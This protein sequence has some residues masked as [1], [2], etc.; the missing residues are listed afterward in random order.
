MAED[1][2]KNS[3]TAEQQKILDSKAKNLVISAS[4]GSGK[5]FILIEKIK[6][7]ICENKVKVEKL[8]VLTF[9]KV[10][11][12]EIKSR[13]TNAILSQKPTKELIESLD[14]LPLSDISTIDSFCEKIIKRNINKLNISENFTILDEKTALKLKKIA[15]LNTYQ[16]F[17]QNEKEKFDEIYFAF[18]KNKDAVEDCVMAL[19]DKFSSL[20]EG[21]ELLQTFEKDAGKLNDLAQESLISYFKQCFDISKTILESVDDG[22]LTQSEKD[23]FALLNEIVKL[24][25][26][27]NIFLVCQNI[28]NIALPSL[29]GR[30]KEE[31][32]YSFSNAKYYIKKAFDI[33]AKYRYIP[34][35]AKDKADSGMLVK[36][37]IAFYRHFIN[38]YNDLKLK[39]SALDFA[40]IE[41]YAKKLLQDDE[42]KKA[43]QERYDYIFI[44][45]YQD[46][47]RLQES[48]LKPISEG[49][50]FTA[51]GDIKQ[52]IYGFRNA[53]ME[54]MLSDI[55]NFSKNLDG[56]AL[57]LNGNFRTEKGILSFV[58]IIFEK[59]MT[60][61]SV[62]I[63]Y[64]DNSM[65]LGLQEFIRD[66]LPPVTVD[67]IVQE[68]KKALDNEE[69]ECEQEPREV[70]DITK[71]KLLG[72]DSQEAE[73]CTIIERIEEVLD[74]EIYDAK[75]KK[76]RRVQQNDIALLFRGRS[77]LM[78]EVVRR[79]RNLG[80]SVEADLKQSL[81][82]D[83][84]IAVICALLKLT[85]N[86]KDDISL[87][88]VMASIFGGFSIDE[89]AELRFNNRES[90]FYDIVLNGDDEKL[91]KFN[92]EID[93]FKFDIQIFGVVKSLCRL[94]N[95]VD[96]YSYLDEFNNARE[97]IAN[98]N[99]LYK[100]IK[101]AD[102][103]YNVPGIISMLE[104][105]T[106]IR[107]GEG[108]SN[109]INVVTI[110]ATKGLEY[111]I[112]ILCDAG[113]GLK[114]VYNK[115]YTFSTKFGIGTTLNDFESMTR[116]PSPIFLASRLEMEKREFIDEIMI[117]YVALTR[118]QNHLYIIGSGK[119]KDFSF[120]I[121]DE[122]NSYL[123][124]IFFAFGEN[125]T[126]QLF[127]QGQIKTENFLFKIK[128]AESKEIKE[129]YQEDII[130]N[131]DENLSDDLQKYV[132][133]VYPGEDECKLSYKNSVTGIMKINEKERELL[134]EEKEIFTPKVV[135]RE[136][137]IL[138]G[139]AY[140]EALK[141]LD[142]NVV[143]SRDDLEISK[144]S[145]KE[146]MTEGY[147]DLLDFDLL[148]KNISVIKDKTKDM[149]LIKER[150]FI[151]L[152]SPQEMGYMSKS[153]QDSNAKDRKDNSLIIQGIVDLFALGEK[154][155]L[156]DYKYTSCQNDEILKE[157]YSRQ[158]ELYSLALSKAF[159]GK[160]IDKYLLSLK[161]GHL[162]KLN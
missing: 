130:Y 156:I 137:A 51:V 40:D 67:V 109:A 112:V 122:Q 120:D 98:I 61:E 93:K 25:L 16:H 117:F 46:T 57:Y 140:H 149:K 128:N 77:P 47:N 62:G 17:S 101:S 138:T 161:E 155:V 7:L 150:E 147:F 127:N 34:N 79:L 115:N 129:R 82:E 94:F 10:A 60:T 125:F 148:Y 14:V 56:E 136:L 111:P 113:E 139:N 72:D 21:D 55:K 85:L 68:N 110:H 141:I 121:L 48:I 65:L 28:N 75:L 1:K 78:N 24:D 76:F 32:R 91:V 124:F 74:R 152:S 135:Y 41:S 81:I 159:G 70:Y 108:G 95:R 90:K 80:L 27:G 15:F 99:S 20:S 18:K 133:F 3:P 50:Y 12:E 151:M 69:N 2:K 153:K 119:E 49:G 103:D 100:L 58:N 104:G 87:A 142:F 31:V 13:L 145:L 30:H 97:K 26:R 131:N 106:E 88:S 35:N 146:K 38:Y 116:I 102:L 123:K 37:I 59:I 9:T 92:E 6:N 118:A 63:D 107:G 36:S 71:D 83:C 22:I 157:R 132:D 45:E 43:L 89:L 73:V 66:E 105:S 96:Y 154:I 162:I 33:A 29:K 86:K 11:A 126:K 54:I 158:I 19:Q 84:N 8:L 134:P 23:A 53:N 144:E 143:N 160:E 52:G 39:R 64:K 42:V 4:A 114:K 5:T 44:D